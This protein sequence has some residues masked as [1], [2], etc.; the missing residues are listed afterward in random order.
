M[1]P[2][3]PNDSEAAREIIQ[4][5]WQAVDYLST[6]HPK[7]RDRVELCADARAKAEQSIQDE[8]LKAQMEAKLE[9]C[10]AAYHKIVNE[11]VDPKDWLSGQIDAWSY[12]LA[13]LNQLKT[14]EER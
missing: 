3:Q 4:E 11:G 2:Q 14:K 6:D 13:Q 5:L 9:W 7:H 12:E 10:H 8:I 1:N